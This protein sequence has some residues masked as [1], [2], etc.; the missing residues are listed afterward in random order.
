MPYVEGES[1]RDRLNREKQLPIDDALT[2]ATEVADALGSEHRQGVVHRDIKPE[3]ILLRDCIALRQTL[4]ETF[5]R[6]KSIR[7]SGCRRSES[8]VKI[9]ERR[10]RQTHR[11]DSSPRRGIDTGQSCTPCQ[12]ERDELREIH[13]ITLASG[14]SRLLATLPDPVM[15]WNVSISPNGRLL[16]AAVEERQTDAWIV[17]DFDPTARWLLI[18]PL[19]DQPSLPDLHG[20]AEMFEFLLVGLYPVTEYEVRHVGNATALD[21]HE[22]AE[23]PVGVRVHHRLHLPALRSF[24]YICRRYVANVGVI[25]HGLL[26]RPA[27]MRSYSIVFDLI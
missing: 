1:L 12:R 3:N 21:P 10:S 24:F 14:R 19:Q 25:D 23:H 26:Q 8:R 17:D 16:V 18:V 5:V 7:A 20:N 6:E 4:K 15:P 9:G 22:S 27:N 13:A 11:G 2:L